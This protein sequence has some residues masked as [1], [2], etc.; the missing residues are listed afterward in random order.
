MIWNYLIAM[1]T[2]GA[3]WIVLNPDTDMDGRRPRQARRFSKAR[4]PRTDI[5][6]RPSPEL[7]W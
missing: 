1:A 6:P 5:A 3:S 7:A 4:L 2:P